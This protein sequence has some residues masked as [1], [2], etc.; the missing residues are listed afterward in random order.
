[1]AD[2][3]SHKTTTVAPAADGRLTERLYMVELDGRRY[4]VRVLVPEPPHSELARRRRERA[5]ATA[6]HHAA[7]RDAVV[8]PMQC[9]VLDVRVT[10][11]EHVRAGHV[12][13]IVE[14]MKMENEIG[15]HRDGVVT[16]LSVAVGEPVK[17][18]QP[19]CILVQAGD[20]ET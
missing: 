7:A 2:R 8:S 14:A 4:H 15:A 17:A 6:V 1:Q 9:T 19:I 12:L 3:L 13:C 18:G 5:G 20:A 10:E 16:E 11:G